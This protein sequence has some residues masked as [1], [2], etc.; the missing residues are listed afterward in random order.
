MELGVRR[1]CRG[2]VVGLGGV[3]ARPLHKFFSVGQVDDMKG[4]RLAE[5]EIMEATEKLDGSMV[6]VAEQVKT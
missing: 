3:R 1:Q 4:R 6:Y 2:L 5:A